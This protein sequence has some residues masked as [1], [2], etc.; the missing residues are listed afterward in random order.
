MSLDA[1]DKHA[2]AAAFDEAR[3]RLKELARFQTEAENR[4]VR[5]PAPFPMERD[6]ASH[7][8]VRAEHL[9]RELETRGFEIARKR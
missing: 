4:I 3:G 6:R 5:K 2:I 9:I 8:C 7:P 1:I